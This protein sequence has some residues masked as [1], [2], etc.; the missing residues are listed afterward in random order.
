MQGPCDWPVVY[1]DCGEGEPSMPIDVLP[2][3]RERAES[4]A[5]AFLWNLTDRA[6]GPCEVVLRPCQSAAENRPSK[7][8][9]GGSSGIWQP[10]LIEGQWYNLT[11]GTCSGTCGCGDALA[12][13]RLPG[14]VAEVISV[15]VDGQVLPTEAYRV[16]NGS[17]LV[18]TD[19]GTWPRWQ[20]F[21]ADAGEPNT[22]VITY[23]RGKPVPEGGQVAAGVLAVEFAKALCDDNSCRLPRRVQSITRQGVTVAVLDAFEDITEG[24]TGIWLID[25]WVASVTRPRSVSSVISPDYR[26]ERNHRVRTW[27]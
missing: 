4:M 19:G 20:D 21:E 18:R 15:E 11:C 23:M 7:W 6:Y 13:L 27:P 12:T 8:V 25:S 9:G 2:E 17:L 5:R 26:P 16:D 3:V 10:V 22:F 24:H 14:P 1:T